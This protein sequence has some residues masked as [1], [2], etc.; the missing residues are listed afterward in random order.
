MRAAEHDDIGFGAAIVHEARRDLA[1]DGVILDNRAAGAHLRQFRE[2]GR[3]NE[4]EARAAAELRDQ[5]AC[6]LARDGARRREH[7]D[8]PAF[9]ERGGGLDGG[10]CADKWDGKRLPQRAEANGGGC[11]AGKDNAI[12]REIVNLLLNDSDEPRAEDAGAFRAVGKARVVSDEK[13]SRFGNGLMGR[14]QDREA[15]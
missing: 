4:V 10:D 9:C 11:V 1:G 14:A 2:C 13:N 7:R 15:A 3:A 6:V 5:F 12:R 8:K